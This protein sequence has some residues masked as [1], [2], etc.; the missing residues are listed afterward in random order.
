MKILEQY[1][2]FSPRN[3]EIFL[4][5]GLTF[6]DIKINDYLYKIIKKENNK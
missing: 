2:L 6:K 5:H 1:Y 3:N 4:L